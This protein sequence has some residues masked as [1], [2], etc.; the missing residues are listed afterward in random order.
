MLTEGHDDPDEL[1]TSI[2]EASGRLNQSLNG[3]F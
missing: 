2:N 3:I 1:I